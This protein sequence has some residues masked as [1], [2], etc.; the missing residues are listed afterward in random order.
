MTAE[1][2]VA[3]RV[4]PEWKKALIG[5]QERFNAIA[6]QDK[7]VDWQRESMFALQALEKGDYLCRIAENNPASL[8]NAIINVAA[9]G[10]TLNPAAQYAALVPRDGA[11]CL[12]IMYRG[13]IK[14][15]T[16]AGSIRW[17][18]ADLVHEA[19][20]FTYSGKVGAPIHKAKVFT[21]RGPVVGVYCV[22]RTADGDTLTEVMSVDEINAI[23]DKSEYYKKTKKGP[24]ADHWGEMAKKTIIKRARKTWP[25]T[26]ARSAERLH[27]ATEIANVTDGY[28]VQAIEHK[29]Q[30]GITA[31]DDSITMDERRAA[32]VKHKERLDTIKLAL[33]TADYQDAAHLWYSLSEREQEVL[34]FA[35]KNGGPFTAQ[36]RKQMQ[37]PQFRQA[38]YV[39]E[40]R[41]E[42]EARA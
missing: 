10:I 34:W 35:Q 19:D 26:D 21:D 9:I 1:T 6:T 20:E 25:E 2:A 17:V 29:P 30:G 23:R 14:I 27:A 40:E 28:E 39:P 7:I 32:V 38:Y 42:A 3:E 15:A 37:E 13:L 33:K 12:D 4:Q 18:Q 24:W 16:D 5:A 22:A 41:P 11:V 36:E 8:R 31:H